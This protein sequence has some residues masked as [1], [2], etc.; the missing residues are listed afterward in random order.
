MFLATSTRPD[1]AFALGQL[2]RF[3]GNYSAK[4]VGTVKRV[5]CYLAGTLDFG[6]TYP[7]NQNVAKEVVLEGIC[8]SDWPND[9]EQRNS[10]MGF[11]FSLAA[12]AVTWMSRRQL[13][14]GLSTTEAEYVAACVATMEAIAESNSFQEILPHL[15]V[16]LK[17]GIDNQAVFIIATNPTYSRRMRHIELG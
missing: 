9:P 3:A 15:S 16:K 6:I 1:L 2:S 13:V 11:V 8:D 7:R 14:I 12:G 10:T 4:H 17:I 5:L